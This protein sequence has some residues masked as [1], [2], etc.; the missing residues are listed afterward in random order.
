MCLNCY[1]KNHPAPLSVPALVHPAA[2]QAAHPAV[3]QAAHPAAH[4]ARVPPPAGQPQAE[5]LKRQK[6]QKRLK[7]QKR[8]ARQHQEQPEVHL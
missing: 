5:L 2:H 3:H 4:Q 7:R 1:P 6:R 8:P